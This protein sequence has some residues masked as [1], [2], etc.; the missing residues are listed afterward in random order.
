MWAHYGG[1]H[2]GI[3]IEYDKDKHPFNLCQRVKYVNDVYVIKISDLK[4]YK[5]QPTNYEDVFIRK[6]SIWSYEKEWRLIYKANEA[7]GYFPD[8]IKAITFGFFC[9]EESI[10]EI[11]KSTSHLNIKYYK[12]VRARDV[13]L[14]SKREL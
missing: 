14:T 12:V 3:C 4:D 10:D 1:N 7:V 13:Y 5:T 8:A 6:N 2:K 9:D 11:K